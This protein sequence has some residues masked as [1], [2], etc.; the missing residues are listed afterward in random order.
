MQWHCAFPLHD[1]ARDAFL[2][3]LFQIAQRMRGFASDFEPHEDGVGQYQ[4]WTGHG[5]IQSPF[6]ARAG[7]VLLR[8]IFQ[9]N[10]DALVTACC[11]NP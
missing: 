4:K 7:R 5:V 11:G 1:V 2:K 8:F 6:E 3:K 9:L 10:R